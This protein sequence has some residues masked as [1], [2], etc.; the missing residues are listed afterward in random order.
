M[1]KRT[2]KI[3]HSLKMLIMLAHNL[4]FCYHADLSEVFL[5]WGSNPIPAPSMVKLITTV[6][7]IMVLKINREKGMEKESK[8]EGI[9]MLDNAA[10]F[11][12]PMPFEILQE[13][14]RLKFV[15]GKFPKERRS[16]EKP[17]LFDSYQNGEIIPIDGVL[18]IYDPKSREIVLF[19]KGITWAGDRLNL[20]PEHLEIVVK[21]HEWSHAIIHI[22]RDDDGKI[23]NL[24]TYNSIE[25]KLH[26]TLA[27][28]WTFKALQYKIGETK[29]NVARQGLEK[30]LQVFK[31]LNNHQPSDYRD[32]GQ[33][34]NVS[35][36]RI[37]AFTFALRKQDVKGKFDVFE[38]L[39]L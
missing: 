31:D 12:L 35:L 38:S 23:C 36:E 9:S 3:Q 32:W 10:E 20:K 14:T 19:E 37:R 17:P 30:V 16:E 39:I 15:S 22:G 21:Y 29:N 2:F 25:K 6:S 27:Q 8:K 34:E 28:L 18:G 13:L 4:P 1:G 5:F 11:F 33:F 26:E 24:G 7:K